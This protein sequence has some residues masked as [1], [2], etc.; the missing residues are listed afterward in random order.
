MSEAAWPDDLLA[1]LRARIAQQPG[2]VWLLQPALNR[3]G[4]DR[5]LLAEWGREGF[6]TA[7]SAILRSD[8][9]GGEA[10]AVEELRP[11]EINAEMETNAARL[12]ELVEARERRKRFLEELGQ[13]AIRAICLTIVES[14]AA[15][16]TVRRETGRA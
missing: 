5:A 10:V 16:V 4:Q 7:L 2:L 15:N 11:N 6:L 14:L 12:A 13:A 1:A 3:L 9:E 8:L